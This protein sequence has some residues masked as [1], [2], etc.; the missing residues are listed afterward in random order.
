MLF[1]RSDCAL[2]ANGRSEAQYTLILSEFSGYIGW[3]K[4]ARRWVVGWV[5]GWVVGGALYNYPKAPR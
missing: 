1:A 3:G 5:G 4:V 2:K